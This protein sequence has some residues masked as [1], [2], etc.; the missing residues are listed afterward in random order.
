VRPLQSQPGAND[1]MHPSFAGH[2][3]KQTSRRRELAECVVSAAEYVF[4]A[5]TVNITFDHESPGQVKRG[6]TTENRCSALLR[7]G[8]PDACAA[9]LAENNRPMVLRGNWRRHQPRQAE[10]RSDQHAP[11]A[12]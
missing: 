3:N 8:M 2:A 5:T 6:P 4:Y 10:H 7:V 9:D 12:S 11:H 1:E